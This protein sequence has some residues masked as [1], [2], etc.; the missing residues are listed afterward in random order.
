ML[1]AFTSGFLNL[2]RGC[3]G[4]LV[5]AVFDRLYVDGCCSLSLFP[6][7]LQR[8]ESEAQAIRALVDKLSQALA[9]QSRAEAPALPLSRHEHNLFRLPQDRMPQATLSA[10]RRAKTV[11]AKGEYKCI[12]SDRV[13]LIPGPPEEVEVVWRIYDWFAFDRKTMAEIARLLNQER[14]PEWPVWTQPLIRGVL[15]GPK[16]AGDAVFNRQSNKLKTKRR[17]NSKEQW[18]RRERAYRALVSKELFN[19]VQDLLSFQRKRY[20]LTY[21]KRKLWELLQAKGEL[22]GELIRTEPGMPTPQAYLARFGGLN[23]AYES[24]GYCRLKHRAFV[25][26]RHEM[27]SL[28]ARLIE[29]L[30]TGYEAVGVA[31]EWDR[32]FEVLRVNGNWTLSVTV[33]RSRIMRDGNLRW[34]ANLLGKPFGD[35][36]LLLRLGMRNLDVLDYHLIPRAQIRRLPKILFQGTRSMLPHRISKLDTLFMRE[37]AIPATEGQGGPCA[38][39]NS[40]A[41]DLSTMQRDWMPPPPTVADFKSNQQNL[42]DYLSLLLRQLDQAPTDEHLRLKD[43]FGKHWDQIP[44]GTRRHLGF[45]FLKGIRDG[46]FAGWT[47]SGYVSGKATNLYRK[48]SLSPTRTMADAV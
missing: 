48:S 22:S 13:I 37:A 16:Y 36:L 1:L 31:T 21:M 35:R 8:V 6:N 11:L 24:V 12:V 33:L 46:K 3:A 29:E 42:R 45:E 28:R 18:V 38:V 2:C 41:A 44:L 43:I 32:E 47:L 10:D 30:I 40:W 7:C 39:D 20:S 5:H 14:P 4:R 9:V 23:V 27:A 26:H 25:E 19:H 17:K 34:G 15:K